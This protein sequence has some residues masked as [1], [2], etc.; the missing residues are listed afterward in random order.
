VVAVSTAV[1]AKNGLLIRNRTAFENSRKITVVVF[2]KTGTLTEGKF[3]VHGIH[4]TDK[5]FDE[6]K[7]IQ[8]A[9]SLEQNSEHPIAGAIIEKSQE[10]GVKIL[11]VS[12]FQSIKGQGVEGV[13]GGDEIKVVSPG[14]LKE[15]GISLPHGGEGDASTTVFLMVNGEVIG[16][17]NLSDAIR[18][19]SYDAVK[20]LKEAGIKCWMLTGDN[21]AVAKQVSDELHL[22]G[23]F[24]E[25]G[26]NLWQWWET[27]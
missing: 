25:V 11:P 13:V 12:E 21:E 26:A 24:A 16:Y 22:D 2:D 3:G 27:A 15:K 14:Y 8:M 5:R 9:A 7:I 4:P 19:E 23:Y 18:K 6:K 1:S 10:M 20:Q 17:I